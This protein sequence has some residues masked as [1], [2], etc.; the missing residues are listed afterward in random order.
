MNVNTTFQ[1]AVLH[2]ART[3]PEDHQRIIGEA[4]LDGTA[5]PDRALPVIQFAD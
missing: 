1:A 3:W 2:V 5:V 4:I